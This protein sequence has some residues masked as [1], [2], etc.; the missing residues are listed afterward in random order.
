MATPKIST[1]RLA[2]KSRGGHVSRA[3]QIRTVDGKLLRRGCIVCCKLAF[4]WEH[5]GVYVGKGMIVHLDGNGYLVKT[6]FQE[7]LER[8]D[9]ANP[10]DSVFVACNEEGLPHC[11]HWGKFCADHAE[12]KYRYMNYIADY[13]ALFRNCH[14]FTGACLG[15]EG[16]SEIAGKILSMLKLDF[17]F[18]WLEDV[19][20]RR[21]GSLRWIECDWLDAM[22]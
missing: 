7:F 6:G 22:R 8:L 17:G 11:S 15:Y 18:S 1:K 9:G 3:V 4:K 13:N 12:L 20:K 10:A 2:E 21:Y 5:S 14:H 19:I 16:E